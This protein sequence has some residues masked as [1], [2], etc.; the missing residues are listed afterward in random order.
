[1]AAFATNYERMTGGCTRLIAAEIVSTVQP[2]ITNESHI[3]D[4][5]CGPGIA[6]QEV[7][8][9]QP[10]ARITC[11]DLSPQML[12]QVQQRFGDQA[13]T[14]LLDVRDLKGLPDDSFTHVVTNLG[15]P[16]PDDPDSLVK[17]AKEMFRALKVGG[18][19]VVSTW[20]GE[21]PIP[22]VI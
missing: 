21:S 2:P 7:Q 1:M 9:T 12:E 5:A 6:A 11:A 19:A 15:F 16:V 18:A 20:S 4:N 14:K 10:G 8:N 13:E 3:L 22:P 17:G